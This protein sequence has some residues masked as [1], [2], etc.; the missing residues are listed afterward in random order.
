MPSWTT[1]KIPTSG[2]AQKAT[3]KAV[4]EVV[5]SNLGSSPVPIPIGTSVSTSS[6]APVEFRTTR[7]GLLESGVGTRVTIPVESLEPG[8]AGNV[9]ANTINTVNGS[10]RFRA[11]V[12]NPSGTFGG[13]AALVPVVTQADKDKLATILQ[14]QAEQKAY[15]ALQAQL[16]PGEW[17][18]PESVQTFVVAQSF[19]QYNDE[20]AIDLDGTVRVLAQGLAVDELQANDI[21][22]KALEAQVPENARLVADS[23]T[24]QRQ[25]GAEFL[26]NSVAFTMTVNADYTTPIDPNEVRGA[27]AGLPPAAAV[28]TLR[29]RWL[30]A[31]EPDIYLDPGWKGTLPAIGSRIQ[32][33]VDYGK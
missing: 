32:V 13:G 12:N 15:A 33:R 17:L 11:R 4:G 14:G 7:E 20:E 2:S 28:A 22:L 10:L 24:V 1:G 26:A 23:V 30:L 21:I 8:T 5:F 6:G 9:R 19:D 3:D 29:E 27:V 18:P 25:P 31:G 16:Q